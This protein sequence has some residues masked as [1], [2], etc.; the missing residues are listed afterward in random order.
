MEPT[1]DREIMIQLDGNI[2][3]LRQAIEK[4]AESLEKLEEGKIK[5]LEERVTKIEK[6]VSEWAGAYKL[7]AVGALIL[8]LISLALKFKS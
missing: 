2:Q 4:F 8:S 1:T 5:N 6:F 3:S 7:I